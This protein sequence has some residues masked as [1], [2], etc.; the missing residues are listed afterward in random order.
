MGEAKKGNAESDGDGVPF[1]TGVLESK[2]QPRAEALFVML[3][4]GLESYPS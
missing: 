2:V 4:G 3:A 1:D